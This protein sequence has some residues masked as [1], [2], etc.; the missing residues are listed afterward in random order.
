[1][2]ILHFLWTFIIKCPKGCSSFF[3]S[4][5][6]ECVTRRKSATTKKHRQTNIATP[7]SSE[8]ITYNASTICRRHYPAAFFR[9]GRSTIVQVHT[10]NCNSINTI[11]ITAIG[12][13]VKG[14]TIP[15]GKGVD[16]AQAFTTLKLKGQS[17]PVMRR[18]CVLFQRRRRR[19]R[20]RKKWKRKCNACLNSCLKLLL[21]LLLL[22]LLLLLS[23][24]IIIIILYYIIFL[25]TFFRVRMRWTLKIFFF[26]RNG[27][28]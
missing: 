18:F 11:N 12:T 1:M 10:T 21:S 15:S 19:R 2:I 24:N 7:F 20:R 23:L 13:V 27:L 28:F 8:L 3:G 6:N 26:Y 16:S 9:I 22:L 14:T 5:R 25:A 4:P 17:T